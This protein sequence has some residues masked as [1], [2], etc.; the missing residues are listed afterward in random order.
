[1]LID[2]LWI[3]SQ[4]EGIQLVSLRFRFNE[5]FPFCKAFIQECYELNNVFFVWIVRYFFE[6]FKARVCVSQPRVYPNDVQ[7]SYLK[8][9]QHSHLLAPLINAD[10]QLV[11]V[12]LW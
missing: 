4:D 5:L 12:V 8:Q 1:M 10:Q 3:F 2:S 9:K 7:T 6:K 11:S